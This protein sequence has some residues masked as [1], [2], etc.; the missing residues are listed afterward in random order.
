MAESAALLADEVLPERPLRQWVLSLPHALR[1]L[2]ATD[3]ERG[4]IER[5]IENA[6]LA[7][8]AE[9]GPLDDLIG[10]SIWTHWISWRV[11]RHWCRRRACT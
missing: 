11:W 3:P 9:P 1:F 7:A 10:H 5:D 4:L 6:W 2:L 8:G